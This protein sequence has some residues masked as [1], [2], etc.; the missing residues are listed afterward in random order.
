VQRVGSGL[1]E[2]RR[3]GALLRATGRRG[4]RP[5]IQAPLQFHYAGLDERVNAGWPAYEAALVANR[6]VYEAHF[7]EGANHGF[8]NDSTPRYDPAAA[9]LA[10]ARTLDFFAAHLTSAA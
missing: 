4:G 7:Y 3:L 2:P 6:K 8:H 1:S 10:W 9:E 5:R